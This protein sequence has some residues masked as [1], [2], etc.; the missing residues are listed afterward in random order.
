MVGCKKRRGV[1]RRRGRISK[2][3]A[4]VIFTG[5]KISQA[6][7]IQPAATSLPSAT[8]ANQ[9]TKNY[10]NV[11]MKMRKITKKT[12]IKLRKLCKITNKT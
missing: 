4:P 9:N 2:R 12:K 1:G 3:R 6:A 5:C 11:H 8:P 10:E 7:K